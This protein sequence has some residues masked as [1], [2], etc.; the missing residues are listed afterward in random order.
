MTDPKHHNMTI[1]RITY[2]LNDIDKA[3]NIFKKIAASLCSRFISTSEFTRIA[4]LLVKYANNLDNSANGIDNNNGIGIYGATGIRKTFICQCLQEFMKIDNVKYLVNGKF[5]NFNFQMIP[6]REIVNTTMLTGS[7]DEFININILLID[8]LG[9]EPLIIKHF[10][11]EINPI[12]ALLEARYRKSK[13]THYTSNFS[14][15]TIRGMY[16]ER[17]YSRLRQTTNIIEMN[18]VDFRLL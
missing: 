3:V 13:I 16:G 5:R 15:E 11:N 4:V 8:D 2:Q 12:E 7:M 10:G 9:T 1:N 14:P 6:S 17:V 18:D